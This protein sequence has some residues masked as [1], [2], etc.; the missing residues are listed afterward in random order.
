M[1]F[2]ISKKQAEALQPQSKILRYEFDGFF[3]KCRAPRVRS[4]LEFAEQEI[5]I[6]DGPYAK[7]RFK[8][9][10]QPWIKLLYGEFDK[11]DFL[12]YRITGPTQSG[13][14]LSATII[15]IMYFLF[16]KKENLIFACP[17]MDICNDKW[18]MDILP[19]I[20]ASR[21]REYLPESG[22]GSRGGKA[23]L[24]EFGN[25][26]VIKFMSGGGGD[27]KRSA[28]TARIVVITELDKL[29]ESGNASRESTKIEQLKARTDA[30]GDDAIIIGEGT[31]SIEEG[32]T[33][34]D[35]KHGT[36]SKIRIKCPI[37]SDY[38]TPER[39]HLIGY[40]EALT[41]MQ[42]K[43]EGQICCPSC[44]S[45]WNEQQ[46]VDANLHALLVH[47]GQSIEGDKVVGERK[48]TDT[49]GFRYT[50]SNNLFYPMGRVS[51][52]EWKAKRAENE[53]EAEKALCQFKWAIPHKP[54]KES[55]VELDQFQLAKRVSDVPRGQAAIDTEVITVSV[56]V[57]KRFLSWQVVGWQQNGSGQIID[58][59]NHPVDYKTYGIEEAIYVA[60]HELYEKMLEGWKD[61]EGE[62]YDF[63]QMWIDA[64][65]QTDA[66][67]NFIRSVMKPSFEKGQVF[68]VYGRG[69]SQTEKFKYNQPEKTSKTV[70]QIGNQ[71]FMDYSEDKGMFQVFINSDYWKTFVHQRF[72][73][74]IEAA[75]AMVLPAATVPNEHLPFAK[76]IMAE[77][78]VEEFEPEKGT[79]IVWNKKKKNNHQL[80]N[81]H[82]NC[83]AAHYADVR[84][85][86]DR[87]EPED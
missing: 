87:E 63:D 33:W 59:G 82:I 55:D 10:T 67:I 26:T 61:T 37:C 19:A 60:L 52:D 22:A 79:K 80:D 81:S 46:R 16:E 56:D 27:E 23:E 5:I 72:A 47:D 30:F 15:P 41:E 36:D 38:V 31:V 35:I 39:D 51:Q 53:D 62:D 69:Q 78:R 74:S 8:A 42:A 29:D 13:K 48:E 73:C 1:G 64:G 68:P 43:R 49:L 24:I 4:M 65:Y 86:Q 20:K 12:H 9:N 40:Q 6:P 3:E 21:Y 77:E 58:Y 83:A 2:V 25:G 50:A 7:Q 54:D 75:G 17:T 66:I 76:Q 71:Y 57:H 28:F 85:I 44:G 32:Q 18:K 14:T 84:I 34:Q 45:A 70:R 11:N